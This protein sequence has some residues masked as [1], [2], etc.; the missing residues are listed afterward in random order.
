MNN[1]H[2]SDADGSVVITAAFETGEIRRGTEETARL[3]AKMRAD[4]AKQFAALRGNV[5]SETA[6]CTESV[7]SAVR[8]MN[9]GMLQTVSV[10]GMG[11][12]RAAQNGI[13]NVLSAMLARAVQFTDVGS[14]MMRNVANGIA[15]SSAVTD[16]AARAAAQSAMNAM[17]KALG[18]GDGTTTQSPTAKTPTVTQPS[19][20]AAG[21]TAARTTAMPLTGAAVLRASGVIAQSAAAVPAARPQ[22]YGSTA[23]GTSD[24]KNTARRDGDTNLTVV[25]TKPVETP[26]AHARALKNT[27][28]SVLYG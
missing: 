15:A 6:R 7:L 13:G 23:A 10:G 28:E 27:V 8:S 25:F 9:A 4:A 14:Q 18:I 16:A 2:A 12:L 22:V 26:S 5:R 21:S 17:N 19:S 20:S 24:G 3:L 1:F 11:I